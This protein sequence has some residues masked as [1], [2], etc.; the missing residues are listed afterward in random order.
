[1]PTGYT[2]AI[3]D[4]ITFNQF[5]MSCARAMGA[6]VTMCDES[7]SAPIPERFEP[8]D[9]HAKA[10]KKAREELGCLQEMSITDS[11]AEADTEFDAETAL[12]TKRIQDVV[13]L[14]N[15]YNA[16]LAQVDA[17]Q[18]PT[19]D[20]EGMKK[21][22]IE[23]LRSSIDFDCST[24]YYGKHAPVRLDARQW[25]QKKID[26]IIKDIAYHVKAHAEEVER[27]ESRNT[28][29]AA[30]RTSLEESA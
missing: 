7:S 3:K 19:P 13:D 2:A 21:F 1:M 26:A 27:T 9:Y 6:C 25:R 8:S 4:D 30:L 12:H 22:M 23:Q 29:L 18:P 17:W 16:M 20:H 10:L 11:A 14:R 15:K 28:W 5:A 24:D